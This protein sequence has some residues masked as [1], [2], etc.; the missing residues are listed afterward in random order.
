MGKRTVQM[1]VV[2]AVVAGSTFYS[3]DVKAAEAR[4][5]GL[6]GVRYGSADFE[7]RDREPRIIITSVDRNG[8][9]VREIIPAVGMVLWSGLLRAR[10]T[11]PRKRT[12]G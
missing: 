1:L 3:G 6:L 10:L 7:G 9:T 4:K 12:T 5:A 8:L 2:M 11:L